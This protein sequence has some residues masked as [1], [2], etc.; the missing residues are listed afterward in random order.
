MSLSPPVLPR[1]SDYIDWIAGRTPSAVALVLGGDRLTYSDLAEQVDR[2]ARSL[3]NAGVAKGDRVATLQTPHPQFIV[4]FLATASIGGIWLGLNPKYRLEELRHA[5]SDAK[6]KV[7]LSRTTIGDR[8]YGEEI[9]ALAAT[10][11]LERVVVFDGDPTAPGA[12]SLASFLLEGEDV[13]DATL[14][15]AR[16]ACG[17][18]DPC[19]IVYTSG[20]TGKPKGALLHHEGISSFS[21]EQNRIWPVATYRSLN[22]LPINHVG[23]IVDISMPTLAGGGELHFMEHFDAQSSLELIEREKI[24]VWASVPSVFSLQMQVPTFG[25]YDLS[26]VEIIIWEGAAMPEEMIRRLAGITPRLATNYGMTETTSAITVLEPTCDLGLLSETVGEPFPGVEVRLA[27]DAGRPVADGQEGE[28]QA[29]S[30]Y[31][32]LGYW[33]NPAATVAAFTPDG[34]FRTGD[35]GVRRPDGRYRIVGRLTEMFKSGGYNVYPREVEVAI[36]SHAAVALAA[37]VSIPDA[38]WQEIGVAYVVPRT[39]ADLK[40]ED[41]EAWCRERL[42]NYKVPKRFVIKR[43]LPL[44]PIGKVDRTALQNQARQPMSGA[45]AA[46]V[47]SRR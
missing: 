10:A 12:V 37:V 43:D 40:P 13:P 17:G 33:Q 6:P 35:L 25:R 21:V 18:R 30:K 9:A 8:A 2:L 27:D 28:I 1:V 20:S 34:F 47:Q 45:E 16:L 19:L 26:H 42:A 22:F 3:L 4:A 23:S 14:A 11:G 39:G 32:L 7:L 29:R 24:T 15:G 38:T 46:G 36:E 31:N 44:L 5:V 41:L